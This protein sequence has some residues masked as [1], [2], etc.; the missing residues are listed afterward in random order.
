MT[1]ADPLERNIRE[2][3]LDLARRSRFGELASGTTLSA[4]ADGGSDRRFFRLAH[5]R[6]TAV[7]LSQPGGGWELDS[8]VEIARFLGRFR[9]GA[10]EIYAFDRDQ[11]IILM[12]D[13]GDLHLE[14][15]LREASPAETE[16]HYSRALD[17]LVEL[18]TSVT[19]SMLREG[20]LRERIF[21]EK[22]LLGETAYFMREFIE[23]YCPVPVPDS[24]E[25]ERRFLAATLEREP[26][27][28]MHRDFQSRNVMLKDGR[29]RIVDFQTA[30]R[31]PGL[32]DAASLLKDAY[33]PVPA[34]LR[35]KLLEEFHAKLQSRG[36]RKGERFEAFHATFTLAGVQRTMQALAAFVKLGVR[37]GKPGFLDSIPNGID[38]LEE[39]VRESGR[40]PGLES[41]VAAIRARLR[42]AREK[43]SS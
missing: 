20:L 3:A 43:G 34:P 12:E 13:L 38:L 17:I 39:G 1:V 16:S 2:A 5:G 25:A 41:M 35:R 22:T 8:Y 36:A 23:G 31:G 40:L 18:E 37:K 30:H 4:I 9:A 28:F 19:E 11:G 26:A 32:Y 27:V 15:A 10:P 24:W 7:V 29:L 42:D 14:D 6:R 33:H 21:D